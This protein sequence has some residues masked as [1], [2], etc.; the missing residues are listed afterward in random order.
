MFCKRTVNELYSTVQYS[1]VLIAVNEVP[2][3][4]RFW[5]G[6]L[7][8]LCKIESTLRLSFCSA[9]ITTY[10]I[11]H[12]ISRLFLIVRCRSGKVLGR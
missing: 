8:Y 9:C 5:L 1:T 12:V 10:P 7:V 3:P 6:V 2:L 11:T 4:G